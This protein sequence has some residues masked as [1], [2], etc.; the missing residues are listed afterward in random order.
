L[1]YRA[2][3]L[4]TSFRG[5]EG[6]VEERLVRLA[7][8]EEKVQNRESRITE[9]ERL[10]YDQRDERSVEEIEELD[11]RLDELM[12][13]QH[14][15]A[16]MP[17]TTVL[18]TEWHHLEQLRDVVQTMMSQS[19][20]SNVRS[21]LVTTHDN[22]SLP[23]AYAVALEEPAECA[24]IN[25]VAEVL[26]ECA[27]VDAGPW[28]GSDSETGAATGYHAQLC[29]RP[30]HAP[31]HKVD[32]LRLIAEGAHVDALQATFRTVVCGIGA[33]LHALAQHGDP[34]DLQ[35]QGCRALRKSASD[36][37]GNNATV[38]ADC[39]ITVVVNAMRRYGDHAGVQEQGCVALLKLA[40][41]DKHK[42]TIAANG[43][44]DVIVR[45]MQRHG[46]HGGVQE[47]GCASHRVL[48][49]NDENKT[50]TAVNMAV[51]TRL[52]ALCNDTVLMRVCKNRAAGRCV[53]W[54]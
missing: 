41:S 15:H 39:G 17:E 26:E 18:S 11:R 31:A 48:A 52:S 43:G 37:D 5:F 20:N 50:T 51:L 1:D 4:E 34:P 45:A 23:Q 8:P 13:P 44:I 53:I 32:V 25:A 35:E 19:I 42:M 33:I 46:A 29:C 36:N 16:G 21:F 2:K 47:H 14:Q 54:P 38:V 28:H 27:A 10:I 7:Q 40:R 49:R 6:M 3:S 30:H 24:L 9:L 22:D 12:E